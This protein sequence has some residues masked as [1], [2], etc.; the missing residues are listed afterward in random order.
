LSVT[1]TTPTT[2][3]V[4]VAGV[5]SAIKRHADAFV[6]LPPKRRKVIDRLLERLSQRDALNSNGSMVIDGVRF[7]RPQASALLLDASSGKRTS[8][9]KSSPTT[10]RRFK[11]VM[12]N[13][14]ISIERKTQDT[15]PVTTRFK[16]QQQRGDHPSTSK[17][18]QRRL[19]TE[20]AVT[21][22]P[23]RWHVRR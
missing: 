3:S 18:S 10:W 23:G 15:T 11:K 6:T 12:Q 17:E 5:L 2:P 1:K 16:K 14:G 13:V 7:S 19:N 4:P 22:A 9:L 21:S 20:F 8:T